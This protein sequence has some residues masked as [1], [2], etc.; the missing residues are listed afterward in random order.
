MRHDFTAL[1]PAQEREAAAEIFGQ[2]G[3]ALDPVAVVAIEHAVD[4]GDLSAMNVPADGAVE[5]PSSRLQRERALEVRDVRDSVLHLVLEIGGD[6]PVREAK[7]L[8]E[9]VDVAIQAQRD[10]VGAIAERFEQRARLDDTVELVAVQD[11]K[12]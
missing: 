9:K 10:R 4:V 12:A 6:G 2:R 5:T 7:L 1:R 8:S 11:Q 3:A